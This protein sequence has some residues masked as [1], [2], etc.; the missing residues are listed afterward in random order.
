MQSL[1][2]ML[3]AMVNGQSSMFMQRSPW[4]EYAHLILEHNL[5]RILNFHAE[6]R[7]LL[8]RVLFIL[9]DSFD[10]CQATFAALESNPRT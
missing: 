1:V 4:N 6:L 10:L 3:F 7:T 8:S 5:R 2:L 9:D